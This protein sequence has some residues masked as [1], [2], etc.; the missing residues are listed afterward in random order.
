MKNKYRE[1]IDNIMD[2]FD[3]KG[4]RDL[5]LKTDWTWGDKQV[6][7][8]S[9]IKKYAL[10]LLE[11]CVNRKLYFASTGGFTAIKRKGKLDLFFGIDSLIITDRG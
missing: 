2:G 8:I 1:Q 9:T 5:M 6:P 3:F 10:S 4:A 11:E 7:N